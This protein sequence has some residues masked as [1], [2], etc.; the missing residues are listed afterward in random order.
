MRQEL[1]DY[2]ILM[3]GA[4]LYLLPLTQIDLQDR[5]AVALKEFTEL[6]QPWYWSVEPD[7][8]GRGGERA[9]WTRADVEKDGTD[10]E[11]AAWKAYERNQMEKDN[12]IE[13]Q[14]FKYILTDG[15]SRLVT[16]QGNEVDLIIDPVTFSWQPPEGWLKRQ[17]DTLPSDPAELKYLFL[18]PMVKDAKTARQIVSRC[19]L[20]AMRGLVT[21]EDL[22]KY[23]AIFQRAMEAAARAGGAHVEEPEGGDTGRERATL[24]LRLPND[25]TT[26]G[27]ELEQDAGRVGRAG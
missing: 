26:D 25:R 20:L 11:K 19:N 9:L 2:V 16:S 5:R 10:E 23:D 24:E 12:F 6:E 18:A 15:T 8:K 13:D 3:N 22:K 4:R 17:N 27:Q 21:E 1:L 7:E 14:V